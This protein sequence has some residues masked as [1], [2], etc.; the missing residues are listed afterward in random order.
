[1]TFNLDPFTVKK[2]G[3]IEAPNGARF[4]REPGILPELVSKIFDERDR[5]KKENDKIKS[6]IMKITMNS[7]YGAVA[8]P[9]CR[10][11]NKDVGEAITGFGREIIKKSKEFAEEKGHKVV[12]GDTDSVFVHI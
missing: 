6:F 1:M 2:D 11:Y 9:K 8:S 3:E 7:F 4:I 10:F 5:A 12:Y